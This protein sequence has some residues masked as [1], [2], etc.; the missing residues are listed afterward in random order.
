MKSTFIKTTAALLAISFAT[1]GWAD[2][3]KTDDQAKQN[4][5]KGRVVVAKTAIGPDVAQLAAD[6]ARFGDRTNDPLALITAASMLK[7]VKTSES[8]ATRETPA[9]EAA[10]KAQDSTYTLDEVLKRAHKMTEGR[11]DLTALL[12]D[13]EEASSRG[14]VYGAR[15]WTDVVSGHGRDR[16]RVTFKGDEVAAVYIKGDGDSDLDLYVY[17]E[18]GNEICRDADSTDT[19][20][21]RWTPAWTGPFIIEIRNLGV[22]NHYEA[23]H[24]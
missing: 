18:N 5:G 10:T 23:M 17:D 6:V 14:A 22:A 11:A 12:T 20:L 1:T 13:V 9:A 15:R 4:T 2:T 7:R 24:N 3:T 8:T 19:M 21:C 16:Y